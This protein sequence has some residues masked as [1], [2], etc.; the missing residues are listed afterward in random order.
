MTELWD[1]VDFIAARLDEQHAALDEWIEKRRTATAATPF[2]YD[3]GRT[4]ALAGI[5][6]PPMNWLDRI[7][8]FERDAA[9]YLANDIESKRRILARHR[10]SNADWLEGQRAWH[11]KYRGDDEPF[12]PRPPACAGCG[13]CGSSRGPTATYISRPRTRDYTKCPELRDLAVAFAH[14]QDHEEGWRP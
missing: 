14:H 4:E 3:Y 1:I 10:P 11:K 13:S 2:S 12:E 5:I 6:T 8:A 9:I 7:P